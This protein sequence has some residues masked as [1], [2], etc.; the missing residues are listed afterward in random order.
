MLPDPPSIS[1]KNPPDFHPSLERYLPVL[2]NYSYL[3]PLLYS[4]EK[5]EQMLQSLH[6]GYWGSLGELYHR[7]TAFQGKLQEFYSFHSEY[8]PSQQLYCVHC[9]IP[10]AHKSKFNTQ[11][12]E[13]SSVTLFPNCWWWI[14]PAI[15]II[16]R[17]QSKCDWHQAWLFLL[18]WGG[19]SWKK[20]HPLRSKILDIN[21]IIMSWWLKKNPATWREWLNSIIWQ[22]GLFVILKL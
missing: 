5:T 12:Q 10:I 14:C 7:H 21:I 4:E 17:S 18:W 9:T 15:F 6:R 16:D 13:L 11:S 8:R 22:L 20:R 2:L 19:A 3:E 1:R